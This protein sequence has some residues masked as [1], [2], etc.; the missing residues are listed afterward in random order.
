LNS[1]SSLSSDGRAACAALNSTHTAFRA[2]AIHHSSQQ[3]KTSSASAL[4]N[5]SVQ[6]PTLSEIRSRIS[7]LDETRDKQLAHAPS[8]S[9]T[10]QQLP[11]P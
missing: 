9:T 5:A 6:V 4:L 11:E 7:M 2:E 8:D 1:A 3:L 10:Q